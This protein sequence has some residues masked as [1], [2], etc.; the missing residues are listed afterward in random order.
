MPTP[1]DLND[2]IARTAARDRRAFGLLYDQSCAA[3]Y[4]Q[5]LALLGNPERAEAALQAAFGRIWCEAAQFRRAQGDPMAWLRAVAQR[6]AQDYA[7]GPTCSGPGAVADLPS[8]PPPT[9]VK[10]Q[11]LEAAAPEFAFLTRP[12]PWWARRQVVGGVLVLAG[13]AAA[14][15][16]G[17]TTGPAV[18]ELAVTLQSRDGRL[19]LLAGFTPKAARLWVERIRGAAAPGQA[20]ELW[21]RAPPTA[22]P[23]SLGV[24]P[25]TQAADIGVPADLAADLPGARLEVSQEPPAGAPSGVPTGAVLAAG[26]LHPY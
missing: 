7:S 8:V 26:A 22:P 15:F 23:V 11:V 14:A 20:L 12:T 13:A 19:I 17:P 25:G 4:S 6:A 10:F 1:N 2:L 18:P 3:L 21:L 9:R 16:F 5:C 24:L